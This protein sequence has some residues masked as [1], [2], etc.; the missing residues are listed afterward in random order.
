MER[1]VNT[2]VKLATSAALLTLMLA[3]TATL[4][5]AD[6]SLV[7]KPAVENGILMLATEDG[8]FKWWFDGRVYIDAAFYLED[9]TDKSDGT[10]LRRGR[11]ALKTILWTDWYAEID[12]DFSSDAEKD[13]DS[14]QVKDAYISWRGLANGNGHLRVGNFKEPFS[15]EEV[16][17]SRY[18]TFMERGLP[19]AFPDGR[20]IGF[21]A[22]YWNP[23]YRVAAGIFGEDVDTNPKVRNGQDEAFA[24]A[25]RITTAPINEDGRLL[26]LGL[27]Y[28]HRTPNAESKGTAKFRTRPETHVDRIRTL[29]TGTIP[30]VK[31]WNLFGTEFAGIYGPFSFQSEYMGLDVIRNNGSEDLQFGGYYATIAY[32]ITKGDHRVY[33]W[34]EAEFTRITPKNE[35][36]GAI[37]LALRLSTIDLSDENIWGGNATSITAGATWYLN[38]NLRMLLN[39]TMLDHDEAPVAGNDDFSIVQLRFLA[40]F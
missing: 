37:E 16:T 19:N 35:K 15:M 24:L 31:Y 18:L 1:N 20:K 8:K 40:A 39:Y 29:D 13:I 25:T 28:I 3:P 10:E 38:S 17:T 26:H 36:Y 30:D 9:K 32:F 27:G 21:E 12:V 7:L 11:F 4:K 2:I 14:P 23:K 6:D 22:A 33:N 34:Q 5:A